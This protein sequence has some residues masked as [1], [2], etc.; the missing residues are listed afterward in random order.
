MRALGLVG[1]VMT[2][3]FQTTVGQQLQFRAVTSLV[4]LEV[5]VTDENG[6]VRGLT[7][8]DFNLEDAGVRQTIRVDET[9]DAPLDLVLVA[10]P[11]E[12]I[13]HIAADQVGRV[14]AGMSA[15]VER[16]EGRDRLAVFV[17]AAPPYR[18]RPLTP[19]KPDFG[20]AAFAAGEF[21]GG[22][23]AAPFDAIA[24]ALG[25][26]ED[27]DRRRAL[28]AFTNAADFRSTTSFD[29]LTNLARR[30]GP[31]FVLVGTPVKI[32]ESVPAV[33]AL[34]TGQEISGMSVAQVSGHVFPA[35][36][37]LL[38]RRTGGVTV[39]LGNGD[40]ARLMTALFAWLRT[41]Y[42]I[43]YAPPPGKGWHPVKVTVR[44]RGASVVVRDGYFVD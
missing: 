38:A 4:R 40:P 9:A 14:T 6:A 27:S 16:V 11:P 15:F 3:A 31:A 26:F 24:V 30:L 5:S 13:A 2:A 32:D 21:A 33:A 20:P 18:L 17:A 34:T 44:R 19:G 37:Q 10:E 29:S 39:N 12:S 22:E 25:A 36:L 41:R 28:V 35:R 42:V 7:A 43:S 23:F 1:V 8:A